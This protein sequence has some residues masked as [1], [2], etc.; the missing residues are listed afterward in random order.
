MDGSDFARYAEKELGADWDAAS[1]FFYTELDERIEHLRKSGTRVTS[2]VYREAVSDVAER[3]K[4]WTT[5][6][7]N[8]TIPTLE[9]V[10]LF[11]EQARLL[12]RMLAVYRPAALYLALLIRSRS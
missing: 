8:P 7:G 11:A 12:A 10:D 4:S 6:D 9:G 1:R 5:R 3:L 2:K